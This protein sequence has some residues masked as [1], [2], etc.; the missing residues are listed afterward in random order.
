MTEQR[1][2]HTDTNDCTSDISSVNTYLITNINDHTSLL[3]S[4]FSSHSFILPPT[5]AYDI[6]TVT[7]HNVRG[8]NNLVKQSQLLNLVMSQRI[9]I[10]GLSETK[11]SLASSTYL[12][13]DNP[14]YCSFWSTHP[15]QQ[16]SGGVGL[17]IKS[18]YSR[19]IQGST[20]GMVESSLLTYI[21]MISN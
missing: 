19:H 4:Y 14:L 2:N 6:L 16:T 17:I 9:S 3:Q 8:L 7:C 21:S 15:S 20:S 10:L 1:L 11:L 5:D 12:Y 13:K 18:P